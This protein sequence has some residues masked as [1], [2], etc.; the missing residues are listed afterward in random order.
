MYKCPHCSEPGISKL[1]KMCLGPAVPA[2]CKACGKKVG[3]PYISMINMVPFLIAIIAAFFVDSLA[4]KTVVLIA[5]F[6]A[7]SAIQLL[8]IPLEPR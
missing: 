2:T 1:R 5:G 6:I 4:V 3:V 8:W 7:G